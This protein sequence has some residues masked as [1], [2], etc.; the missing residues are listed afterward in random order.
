[1]YRKRFDAR[2]NFCKQRLKTVGQSIR[3]RGRAKM[4]NF[5]AAAGKRK[6]RK[7]CSGVMGNKAAI[8]APLRASR[9]RASEKNVAEWQRDASYP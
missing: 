5:F 7:E 6:Y 4:S 3:A 1:M 2:V 8:L 9:M